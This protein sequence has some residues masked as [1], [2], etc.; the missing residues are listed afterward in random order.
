MDYFVEIG[1][2]QL[3]KNGEEIC[4]DQ[5]DIARVEDGVIAVMSDGLGS[6]I[7]AN[8]LATLTSKI[9][10]TMLKEGL[11]LAE[12]LDTLAY[13]LPICRV[14]NIAYST[15]TI[16]YAKN[17]GDVYI[18]EYDNP[19]VFYYNRRRKRVTEIKGD[20]RIINN[21]KINEIECHLDEGDCIIVTSDGVIHAGMGEILNYGWEWH[22]VAKYLEDICTNSGNNAIMISKLLMTTCNDLYDDKPQDDATVLVLKRKVTKVIDIFT[23]P[24]LQKE[25]DELVVRDFM[26]SPGRKIICGGTA[27]NIVSRQLER[28]LTIDVSTLT[29]RIPPI[30]KMDGFDLITEGLVTLKY[31]LELLKEYLNKPLSREFLDGLKNRDGAA[32]L[33][34]K[35]LNEGTHINFFLGHSSNIAHDDSCVFG[36]LGTKYRIVGELINVLKKLGKVV[37]IYYF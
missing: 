5:V 18:A 27:A 2:D 26:S 19:T 6:G 24:P 14:R 22:H 9:A 16:I 10:I 30:S 31:T 37:N 4:G 23:G 34:N 35:L 17:N 28:S 7:K 15:F 3:I 12:V 11:G 20:E 8:I 13:T 21:K 29:E 36:K 1:Y 25:K 32:M 33:T